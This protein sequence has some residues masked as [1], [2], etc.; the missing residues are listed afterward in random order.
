MTF[1]LWAAFVAVVIVFS[2]IPGPTVILVAGQARKR[3]NR[4][5]EGALISANLLSL[6]LQRR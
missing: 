3:F 1:E 4:I 2:I 5:D 6:T